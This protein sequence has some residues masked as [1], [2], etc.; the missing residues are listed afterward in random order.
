MIDVFEDPIIT[1]ECDEGI[2]RSVYPLYFTENNFLEFYKQASQYPVLYGKDISRGPSSFREMFFDKNGNCNGLFW[3]VDQFVGV[4][5][6][7]DI[8][9]RDSKRVDAL[10]HYSFFDRRHKG[11]YELTKAMIKYVFDEFGFNRL[12]A[13]VPAYAIRYKPEYITST[14]PEGKVKPFI[15]S[16]GFKQEGRRRKSAWYKD[17]WFDVILYGILRSEVDKWEP[18]K[19]KQ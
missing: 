4:Y 9:E 17:D 8:I 6:L 13:E 10:V 7:T 5:Y 1:M 14:N 12:S 19:Q 18:Q 15:E 3:V 2:T 11:R 16:L